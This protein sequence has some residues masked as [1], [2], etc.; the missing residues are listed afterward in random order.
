M[1]RPSPGAQRIIAIFNLLATSPGRAFSLTDLINGLKMNRSTCHSLANELVNA[2][3][4]YRT[5]DK[6]YV[7]GAAAA[8][9]GQ[10]AMRSMTQLDIARPEMERLA[11]QYDVVC[12]AIFR[13]GRDTV[14][15][16]RAVSA[17]HLDWSANRPK[18]WTIRPPFDALLLAWSSEKEV[19]RWFDMPTPPA[20]AGERLRTRQGMTFIQKHGFQFIFSHAPQDVDE[21]EMDWLP[22]RDPATRLFDIGT[23]LPEGGTV[24][25]IS[26][27]SA[28]FEKNRIAFTLN[29]TGFSR[30]F[31]GTEVLEIGNALRAAC[32]RVTDYHG[33]MD[34]D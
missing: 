30:R 24:E 28:V 9:L 11:N 19:E 1:A 32:E 22:R 12:S 31:S 3:Y 18:R 10:A 5:S 2:G 26:V 23:A 27:A 15:R 16:E 25:L 8:Q 21:A 20:S 33:N 34:A 17:S 4:L 6:L 7:L 13:E 29:M 14:L